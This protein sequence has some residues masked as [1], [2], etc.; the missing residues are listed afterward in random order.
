MFKNLFSK[1]EWIKIDMDDFDNPLLDSDTSCNQTF[2]PP[3][4]TRDC[5]TNIFEFTKMSA[6][7]CIATHMDQDPYA[8]LCLVRDPQEKIFFESPTSE[9]EIELLSDFL[10]ISM[11]IHTRD[12]PPKKIGNINESILLWRENDYYYL[13]SMEIK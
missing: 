9:H 3:G 1:K 7:N 2:R 13:T 6:I 11:V 8:L 5:G 10:N 12:N 4:P